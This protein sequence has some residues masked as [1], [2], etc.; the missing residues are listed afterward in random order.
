MVSVPTTTYLARLGQVYFQLLSA[1]SVTGF[2][3]VAGSVTY[4]GS[5]DPSTV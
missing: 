2:S 4:T 3:T 5:S 1:F